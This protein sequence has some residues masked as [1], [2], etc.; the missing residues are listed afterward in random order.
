MWCIGRCL[1]RRCNHE[2]VD[3]YDDYDND[4]DEKKEVKMVL[5]FCCSWNRFDILPN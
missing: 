3:D 4:D 5:P 1:D 2:T